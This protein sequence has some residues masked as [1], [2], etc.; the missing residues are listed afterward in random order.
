MPKINKRSISMAEL[1]KR[2]YSTKNLFDRL[3]KTGKNSKE[4]KII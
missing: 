2:N 4:K 1:R 3:A